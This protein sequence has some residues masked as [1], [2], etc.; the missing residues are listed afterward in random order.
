MHMRGIIWNIFDLEKNLIST[1]V[2]PLV[3][4]VLVY[5]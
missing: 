3:K 1:A 5:A 2:N 4:S